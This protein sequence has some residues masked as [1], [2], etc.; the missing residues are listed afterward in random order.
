MLS[1]SEKTKSSLIE[2]F[3]SEYPLSKDYLLLMKS[4]KVK[5]S[6]W[7]KYVPNHVCRKTSRQ[8]DSKIEDI[9]SVKKNVDYALFH[10]GCIEFIESL[11]SPEIDFEKAN[12]LKLKHKNLENV[13]FRRLKKTEYSNSKTAT[14]RMTVTSG[15][16]ILTA[17]SSLRKCIKSTYKN[18]HVMQID[19][20]SA[21][22]KFALH[23]SNI[24]MPEDVYDDISKKRNMPDLTRLQIKT[25]VICSLYGQSKS[26]LSN[27][28]PSNIDAGK[29]ISEVKNYF[30]YGF[31]IKMLS[32]SF[33][34]DD[35]RNYFGRPLLTKDKGLILSHYLQSSV[36]DCSIS[37]FSKFCKKNKTSIKPYYIIH[38]ALIFD[39]SRE[40]IEKHRPG[41]IINLE[42]SGVNLAAKITKV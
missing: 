11:Q 4:L 2:I 8:I 19:L 40:F 16:N 14:G 18:G 3:G 10:E 41:S 13:N 5:P 12:K 1:I 38:D 30:R 34:N 17:P 35:F 21:E 27:S 15:F 22:P 33:D 32:N 7:K 9:F 26:R 20:I 36:A 39:A 23:V 31:L 29:V 28:L 24:D 37:M 42:C 6:D 25:A